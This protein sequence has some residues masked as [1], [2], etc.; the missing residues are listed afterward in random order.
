MQQRHLEDDAKTPLYIETVHKRGFRF[1]ASLASA[2]PVPGSTFNRQGIEEGGSGQHRR[3]H[4]EESGATAAQANLLDAGLRQHDEHNIHEF[5][6]DRVI[7]T[8]ARIQEDEASAPE[9]THAS[10]AAAPASGFPV[11]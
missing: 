7:P 3:V 2:P 4:H 9:S 1:I 10:S 5:Y 11:F 8:Q 6:G